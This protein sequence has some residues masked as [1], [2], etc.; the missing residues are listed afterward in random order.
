MIKAEKGEIEMEGSLATLVNELAVLTVAIKDMLTS[1]GIPSEDFDSGLA[2]S[3]SAQTMAYAGMTV[4]E[5]EEIL[6]IPVDR[7][8]S[9]YG[10]D[11]RIKR[12]GEE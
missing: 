1:R 5:V 6:D 10:D 8:N 3:I 11:G 7:E 2:L 12:P 9:Y 4:D